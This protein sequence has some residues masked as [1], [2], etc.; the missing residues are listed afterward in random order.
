MYK[1]SPLAKAETPTEDESR[2]AR[3]ATVFYEHRQVQRELLAAFVQAVRIAMVAAGLLAWARM[4]LLLSREVGDVNPNNPNWTV[5]EG[6]L[7]TVLTNDRLSSQLKLMAGLGIV[8]FIA[9][10]QYGKIGALTSGLATKAAAESNPWAYEMS[11]SAHRLADWVVTL[12]MLCVELNTATMLRDEFKCERLNPRDLNASVAPYAGMQCCSENPAACPGA[13]GNCRAY[14][15]SWDGNVYG[16]AGE[17][18]AMVV[19]GAVVRLLTDDLQVYTT[20]GAAFFGLSWVLLGAG[21]DAAYFELNFDWGVGD[22]G[23]IHS[24]GWFVV[25]WLAYGAVQTLVIAVRWTGIDPFGERPRGGGDSGRRRGSNRGG[26]D[27][28]LRDYPFWLSTVQTV[29]YGLLDVWCKAGFAVYACSAVDAQLAVPPYGLGFL[30][31]FDSDGCHRYPW[32]SGFW[33]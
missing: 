24:Y 20:I 6:Q 32:C 1:R 9:A 31:W 10:A 26:G 17:L 33:H 19:C 18:V 11:T 16:G 4:L 13:D 14:D 2:R 23:K 22:N 27:S 12:P 25:P 8:N 7:I 5:I 15:C 29:C 21:I 30:G 28:G 3:V